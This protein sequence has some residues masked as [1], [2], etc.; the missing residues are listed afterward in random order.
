MAYETILYEQDG[1]IARL[2][3]NR[4]DKLNSLT[5]AMHG[6]IR[7]C[8]D[9][10]ENAGTRVLILTGTGRA[11]CA[12]QDLADLDFSAGFELGNLLESDFNPLVRRLYQAKF[13][14]ICA[15]NGIA[16]GAGA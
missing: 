12:G 8:L 9:K 15:V 13:P 4:P 6:E 10:I 7:D 11:F 5:A 2:A 1:A 14:V 16:A 3:F